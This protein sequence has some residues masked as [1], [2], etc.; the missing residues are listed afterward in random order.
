M[1]LF[2]NTTTGTTPSLFTTGTPLKRSQTLPLATDPAPEKR[3]F[4]LF[5][6]STPATMAAQ[7][8]ASSSLF[9][10]TATSQPQQSGGL[11]SG[12]VAGS[13]QPQQG[14]GLFARIGGTSQPQPT[15][16]GLFGSTPGTSLLAVPKPQQHAAPLGGSF[17]GT[18]ST[19]Q[20]VGAASLYGGL[21]SQ[22][23]QASVQHTQSQ[24]AQSA[25]NQSAY[26]DQM[27]ERGKKRN[28]LENGGL[29]DLPSL[30][31]GLADIARK[32][33]NLGTGGPT[34]AEARAGDP[35][36]YANLPLIVVIVPNANSI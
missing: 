19:A 30:H 9:S 32:A 13:S 27:L 17:L 2:G 21:S 20:H 25:P 8:A 18:Q 29:G 33:R 16:T 15:P 23:A 10:T 4:S 12:A 11:F 3:P 14:G 22:P 31:L 28:V 35:R 36:A 7:P 34:A 6:S 24:H 26:F 1:S 5:P